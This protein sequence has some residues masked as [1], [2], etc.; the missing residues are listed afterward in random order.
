[1]RL[2]GVVL[3]L[4]ALPLHAAQVTIS[5]TSVK[6]LAASLA[7]ADALVAKGLTKG[8]LPAGPES[9]TI[10]AILDAKAS[11]QDLGTGP[12]QAQVEAALSIGPA[13]FAL[14]KPK[15]GTLVECAASVEEACALVG[16]PAAR[17]SLAVDSCRGSCTVPS[18]QA[19]LHVMVDCK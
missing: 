7:V 6:E 2:I 14:S 11:V 3:V 16:A 12:T 9:A 19:L 4:V 18:P 8:D 17:V 1:M 5:K 13:T 15:C 10:V